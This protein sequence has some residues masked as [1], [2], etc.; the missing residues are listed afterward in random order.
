MPRAT[1][2]R[3]LRCL[4]LLSILLLVG[5]LPAAPSSTQQEITARP[6]FPTTVTATP[7]AGAT[8]GA[9][10]RVT[11][12]AQ[13]QRTATAATQMALS[14]AST[15][16]AELQTATAAIVARET[17]R[18]APPTWPGAP[19]TQALEVISPENAGRIRELARSDQG[20][21]TGF[22]WAPNGK[23][24]GLTM[25]RG[26]AL[27]TADTFV[28]IQRLALSSDVES[29]SFSPDSLWLAFALD[30]SVELWNVRTLERKLLGSDMGRDSA[31]G[32]AFSP[33]AVLLAGSWS[34]GSIVLWDVATGQEVKR[35]YVDKMGADSLAFSP[36]GATLASGCAF[37][38]LFLWNVAN[39]EVENKI[40]GLHDHVDHLLFSPD[41]ASLA[42]ATPRDCRVGL[43]NV[44]TR[45]PFWTQELCWVYSLS[46]S[47]D[48]SLLA[49]GTDE[50]T[51]QLWETS[52]GL[53]VG[54][55]QGHSSY[56]RNVAFSP[57]GK[58]LATTA[59]E[60]GT[61]RLWAVWTGP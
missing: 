43:W 42:A 39:G 27:Y 22:L 58:L 38:G 7:D 35:L 47:P 61:A 49:T 23:S 17:A 15:R 20:W 40:E 37:G 6:R 3:I 14:A 8:K 31:T 48:G 60:D 33:D 55:F 21:I 13:A 34:S 29:W 24:I 26:I 52:S 16:A 28:E 12:T 11:A 10:L 44:V 46:F 18:V 53:K 50:G 59:P 9:L 4:L 56:V 36:D 32:L 19:F 5:C 2:N 51:V 30:G 41:G 45:E 57:N 54:Q 25:P 1:V